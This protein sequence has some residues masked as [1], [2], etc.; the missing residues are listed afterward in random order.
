LNTSLERCDCYDGFGLSFP[1]DRSHRWQWVSGTLCFRMYIESV[2]RLIFSLFSL[3]T[4]DAGFV[5]GGEVSANQLL[6]TTGFS[7]WSL[8]ALQIEQAKAK[9]A[10]ENRKA[11]EEQRKAAEE[12]RKQ[13]ELGL[14]I[15]KQ[16]KS[17]GE[18]EG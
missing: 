1:H 9:A 8:I 6:Q 13:T 2:A 16:S 17:S 18:F 15:I 7:E 11:A 12:Q 4:L 14:E 10:E 5:S 3:Q